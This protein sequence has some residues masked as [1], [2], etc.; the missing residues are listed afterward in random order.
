M[1][2]VIDPSVAVKWFVDEDG[3]AEARA[4]LA[5]GDELFAPDL[6]VCEVTNILW[7]KARRGEASSEQVAQACA[8]LVADLYEVMPS[9]PLMLRA[10]ELARDLDHPAYDCFYL[11]CA[12]QVDAPLVTADQRLIA[13][14]A[15]GGLSRLVT[16]LHA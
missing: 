4:L 8:E 3:A 7:K 5:S 9:A 11:A 12:E 2:R 13:A 1:K 10:A 16:P 6:I 14:T 15:R